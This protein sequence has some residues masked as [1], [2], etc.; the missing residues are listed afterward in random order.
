MRFKK[1]ALALFA[2]L[3]LGAFA[4]NS[5]SAAEGEGWTVGGTKIAFGSH[6]GVSCAKHSGSTLIF[7]STLLGSEV[8]LSAEGVDC[9]EK[10]GSTNPATIDN[11]YKVGEVTKGGPGHSEGVLTFT[12]VSVLKPSTKCT[13]GN[14]GKASSKELTT[15]ALTDQ[16]IMDP[17]SGS[18]TVFDKF[19]PETSGGAF[20]TIEF[21]GAE[22]P[23]NE[24][25]A[26]VKG[27]A[28]GQ[29]PNATGVL[30]ATQTLTFG[31][32][33]QTTGGCALTLGT[34]AAGLAGSIDNSLAG[35]NVGS[36]FGSD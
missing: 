36:T 15:E 9:L 3:A 13:V 30:L 1:I 27:N 7:T 4:A 21:G 11:G 8:E 16:V 35:T 31:A 23:L 24:A 29:S 26:P 2:C 28:C 34:K 10:A 32:T 33:Q 6:Q 12:G 17:T 25:S 14:V 18:K 20:V 22:C 5:A 19:S